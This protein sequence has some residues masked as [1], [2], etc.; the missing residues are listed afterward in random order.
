MYIYLFICRSDDLLLLSDHH[1]STGLNEAGTQTWSMKRVPW[2]E[3]PLKKI[4]ALSFDDEGTLYIGSMH[5]DMY[6]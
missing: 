6:F 4:T 2:F 3:D 5:F 1:W